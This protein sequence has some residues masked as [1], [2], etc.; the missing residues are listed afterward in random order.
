MDEYYK[1]IREK[2][3]P[4]LKD[5]REVYDYLFK[6]TEPVR[7]LKGS[8]SNQAHRNGLELGL[9]LVTSIIAIFNY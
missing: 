5:N 1:N 9:F 3:G 2:V 4:L 7:L 6:S 8:F